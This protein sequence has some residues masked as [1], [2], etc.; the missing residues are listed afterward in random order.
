MAAPK[1]GRDI[2]LVVEE[3]PGVWVVVASQRGV[4]FNEERTLIDAATKDDDAMVHLYG[5]YS[6]S[7][8][9]SSLWVPA[10]ASVLAL[11][12]A[13]RNKTTIGVRRRDDGSD[14]EQATAFVSSLSNDN[15]D[16]DAASFSATLNISGTWGAVV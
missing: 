2:L 10:E 4:T 16:D 13:L 7:L 11:R 12:D 9:L 6:A 15:A 8:D 5:R 3:S 14:I 1:N